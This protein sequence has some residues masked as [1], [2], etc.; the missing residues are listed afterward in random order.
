MTV[1]LD[2]LMKGRERL[3]LDQPPPASPPGSLP[4]TWTPDGLEAWRR[5]ELQALQEADEEPS[6]T[7]RLLDEAATASGALSVF[8][9]CWVLLGLVLFLLARA[10]WRVLTWPFRRRRSH[11]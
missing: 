2:D 7:R 9:T 11:E 3:G 6:L 8:L 4:K 1:K 5:R 10:A